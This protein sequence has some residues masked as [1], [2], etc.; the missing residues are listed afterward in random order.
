MPLSLCIDAGN[1]V[2]DFFVE[3]RC[4]T[5]L[6]SFPNRMLCYSAGLGAS[7]PTRPRGSR[8]ASSGTS[9][10]TSRRM[11]HLPSSIKSKSITVAFLQIVWVWVKPS[12]HFQSSNITRTV[13]SLCLY[14]V[15]RNSMTTGTPSRLTTKTIRWWRTDCVMI[16]SFIATSVVSVACRQVLTLNVLTGATTT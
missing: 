12:Q 8:K 9:F 14:F 5:L 11:P 6:F 16:Y 15:P 2:I 7:C 10:T 4:I 13:T 1:K 3:G